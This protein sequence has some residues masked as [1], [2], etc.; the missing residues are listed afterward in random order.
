VSVRSMLGHHWRRHGVVFF[1]LAL[2]LFAFEWL[3][4]RVAPEAPQTQA[5]QGILQ[6]LPPA[7]VNMLGELTANFNAGGMIG[8]G[9][10]H[11]FALLMMGVWAVRLTAGPLAGEV[12]ARTMDLIASRPV[13]RG[14]LVRAALVAL[15]VG[16]ALLAASAWCGTAVGLATRR[17]LGIAPW[18][19]LEVA[20]VMWLLFAAFGSV[21]LLIAA[22]HRQSGPA[23]AVSAGI[24]AVSFALNFIARSWPPIAWSRPLSLFMYYR[25]EHIHDAGPL[26]GDTLVLALVGVVAAALAFPIFSRRDL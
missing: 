11:P 26:T 7:L 13:S 3:I 8:F 17:S 23:M 18:R 12:G 4:T 5:F 14:A 1:A 16:L 21:S 6:L 25:P 19:Y 15:L 9:Y 10:A 2:A 20:F 24:I 22:L